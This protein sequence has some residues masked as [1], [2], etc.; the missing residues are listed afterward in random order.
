MD[1]L[2][3]AAHARRYRLYGL[4]GKGCRNPGDTLVEA[5]ALIEKY[6]DFRF[7]TDGSWNLQQLLETRSKAQRD[8]ILGLIRP[9][10]DRRAR[11]LFQSFDRLRFAGDAVPLALLFQEPVT[12][13]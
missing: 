5:A 1:H 12:R 6:P 8:Q 10:Q 2:C 13:I 9:R 4:S 11:R 7:A 3:G